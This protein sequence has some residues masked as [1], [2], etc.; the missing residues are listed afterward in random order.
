[1]HKIASGTFRKVR[2][3]SPPTLELAPLTTIE[4]AE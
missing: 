2:L 4:S 3:I 1:M